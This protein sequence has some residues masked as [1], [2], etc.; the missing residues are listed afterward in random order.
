MMAKY[1]AKAFKASG[2]RI[3][4]SADGISGEL[5]RDTV[6][7]VAGKQCDGQY[8]ITIGKMHGFVEVH[9]DALTAMAKSSH[10]LNELNVVVEPTRARNGSAFRSEATVGFIAPGRTLVITHNGVGDIGATYSG[11]IKIRKNGVDYAVVSGDLE[12]HRG[13]E[14]CTIAKVGEDEYKVTCTYTKEDTSS[15]DA[16]VSISV[17]KESEKQL[18]KS[19]R[20]KIDSSLSSLQKE[21][22]YST[23]HNEP[24]RAARYKSQYDGLM[25]CKTLED[26]LEVIACVADVLGD[27]WVVDKLNRDKDTAKFI[28][29]EG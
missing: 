29:M 25:K 26:P 16:T 27:D 18:L 22:E 15:S 21:I 12:W 2:S 9:G 3:Y 11:K 4:V 1:G 24:E 19:L 20:E 13:R 5:D 8:E 23:A 10:P 7:A 6:C 14:I 17:D 28:I